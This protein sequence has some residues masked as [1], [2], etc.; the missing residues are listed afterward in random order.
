M[1]YQNCVM[2]NDGLGFHKKGEK[3]MKMK[4]KMKSFIALVL[5]CVACIGVVPV[6]AATGINMDGIVIKLY[7][8]VSSNFPVYNSTGNNKVQI[9]TCFYTDFVIIHSVDT[10]GYAY[11]T[12]PISGGRTKSGFCK[13]E[14]LFQNP[15][16]DGARGETV[17]DVTTYTKSDCRVKFGTSTVGDVCFILGYDNGATQL[18]YSCSGYYK[19][20]WLKG[21]YEIS[22]NGELVKSVSESTS[23]SFFEA[24][25]GKTLAN[26]DSFYY[27]TGNISYTG[28]YKGQ[29]TWYAYGRFY[30]LTG[31]NLKSALHAK[32]WLSANA[33]DGRVKVLYGAGNIQS[34][35]IAVRTSGTWG[36]V[37]FIED[38]VFEN[39][40][41]K[42][43]YFTECN[44]DA[45]GV[46]NS[47]KDAILQKLS[48]DQF[49]AQKKPAG[50]IIA[51]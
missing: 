51:R 21:N 2:E 48:Y 15:D 26:I 3:I 13:T 46:Y 45:N 35:A 31:I 38:V 43:V 28:G 1:K 17:K 41:P 44:A 36:H 37:M 9:G 20:G 47:G 39:G 34:K 4:K 49:V 10:N 14:N 42:W 18:L 22:G 24:S 29:C 11:I 27:T 19:V 30:E 23:N 40:A 7:P 8:W 50:Y 33:S 5:L 25:V 6:H 12:Y 32:Y 16:F